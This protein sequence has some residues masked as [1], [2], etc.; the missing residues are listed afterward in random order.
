MNKNFLMKCC[1]SWILI[2]E[3]QL[4]LASSMEDD[5]SLW[6][7][8]NTLDGIN[9]DEDFRHRYRIALNKLQIRDNDE[10]WITLLDIDKHR[11]SEL[12]TYQG[13]PQYR[14]A[15][16]H[17][18]VKNLVFSLSSEGIYLSVKKKDR[19]EVY[20]FNLIDKQWTSLV[21]YET[22]TDD[23]TDLKIINKP[24]G[25][26]LFIVKDDKASSQMIQPLEACLEKRKALRQHWTQEKY[27]R[28]RA[29]SAKF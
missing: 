29:T 19:I 6:I 5:R 11:K 21:Y 1:L 27:R 13:S 23:I 24:E 4:T 25:V 22:L 15:Q 9:F 16:H 20:E 12:I 2:L 3:S 17:W 8:E 10:Q 26:F 7:N 28:K 18:I 14:F